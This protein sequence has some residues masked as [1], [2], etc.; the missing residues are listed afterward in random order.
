MIPYYELIDILPSDIC[1]YFNKLA[2]GTEDP[3]PE[4]F[5]THRRKAGLEFMKKSISKFMPRKR[6]E[7]DPVGMK[8]NPT[9]SGEVND[10][11]KAIKRFETRGEGKAAFSK[12]PLEFDEIMSILTTNIENTAFQDSGLHGL[13]AWTFQLICRVDDATNITYSNLKYNEDHP[14]EVFS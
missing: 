9:R 14:D 12:R 5:P 6:L 3:G 11:L 2:Y 1:D 7:W 8:G 13:W 10:L 4:D